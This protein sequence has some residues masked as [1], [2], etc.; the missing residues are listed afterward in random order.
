M[1][2]KISN[3]ELMQKLFHLPTF[4]VLTAIT[5]FPIIY[6]I[7]I[8]FFGY[9]LSKP[10]SEKQFVGF[11]NFIN[12]FSDAGFWNSMLVT[13]KFVF[14]VTV[15]QVVFGLVIALILNSIVKGKKILT[16][17][18]MVP[19]MV[20]PLIVGLMY[21]FIL[22]PQFGL[23]TFFIDYF[24]LPLTIS[25]LSSATSALI[26][27]M[28]TDIWEWTPFMVLMILAALQSVPVSPYEAAMIDG[29]TEFQT[30]RYITLPLIKPVILVATILRA[31]EAF[32]EFDKPYILTGGGPGAATEVIDMFTYR[33]AFINF[34]FSYAAALSLVLFILLLAGGI[35]YGRLIMEQEK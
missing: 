1:R 10:G 30:L 14:G 7:Y 13:V 15:V 33:E 11:Q 19:M 27:M 6:S 35:L 25:P 31:M 2:K 9:T 20:A 29:A 8:S 24:N 5:L 23:Y 17:L 12:I 26:V 18:V 22:N 16:S 21:S 32:K 3:N 4:L 28:I 34:N